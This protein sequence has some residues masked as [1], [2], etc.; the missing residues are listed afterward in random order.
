MFGK[1]EIALTNP[2]KSPLTPLKKRMCV[3]FGFPD[4]E[5]HQ[6][7]GNRIKVPLLGALPCAG[8]PRG[9]HPLFKGDLAAPA[10]L[11]FPTVQGDKTGGFTHFKS[12]NWTHPNIL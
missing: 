4:S 9:A 1:Y 5:A 7:G 12:S 6:A 11:C 3:L 8:N 10:R 2:R